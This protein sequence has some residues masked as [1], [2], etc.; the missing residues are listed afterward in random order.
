MSRRMLQ[1]ANWLVKSM[2]SAVER[3][4]LPKGTSQ[5]VYDRIEW[6]CDSLKDLATELQEQADKAEDTPYHEAWNTHFK[7]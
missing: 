7:G 2:I 5:D 3:I 4:S 1:D 6:A